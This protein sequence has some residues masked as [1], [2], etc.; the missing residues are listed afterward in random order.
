MCHHMEMA[1]IRKPINVTLD[2]DLIEALDALLARQPYKVSRAAF[3]EAAVRREV[4]DA[5]AKEKKGKR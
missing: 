3:I 1:R 5:Q 2:P 4:E